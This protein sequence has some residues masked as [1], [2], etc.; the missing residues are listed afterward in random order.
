MSHYILKEL[1]QQQYLFVHGNIMPPP[2]GAGA[3]ARKSFVD[4]GFIVLAKLGDFQPKRVVFPEETQQANERNPV[5]RT[6]NDDDEDEGRRAYR[7]WV[8]GQIVSTNPLQIR[9]RGGILWSVKR[10]AGVLWVRRLQVRNLR[11]GQSVYVDAVIPLPET[12]QDAGNPRRQAA[13]SVVPGPVTASQ[14]RVLVNKTTLVN[15]YPL[16]LRGQ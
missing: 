5:V 10:A 1:Q 7:G 16:Y 2:A 8:Q 11:P 9:D 12:P 4:A 3:G 15:L 6:R 14:I 13:P